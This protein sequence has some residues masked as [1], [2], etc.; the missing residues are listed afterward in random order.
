MREPK[1]KRVLLKISGQALAGD[2]HRG[3][4]FAVIG[5]VFDVIRQCVEAGVQGRVAVGAG[6]IRRGVTGSDG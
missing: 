5:G 4:D 1:Y 3:Q 6:N 2:E